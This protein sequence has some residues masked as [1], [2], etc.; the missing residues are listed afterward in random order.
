[1]LTI[2]LITFPLVGLFPAI[3]NTIENADENAKLAKK[4]VLIITIIDLIIS[5][6]MWMLFNNNSKS[7]QFTQE[8][9]DISQYDLFLGCDGF[10]IYFGLLTT[11][12]IPLALLSN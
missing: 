8:T 4:L 2:L 10:S 6:V 3:A 1:M 11:I 5:F 7:I 9:K 12:I